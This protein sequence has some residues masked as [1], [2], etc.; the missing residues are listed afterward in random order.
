[1]SIVKESNFPINRE[2]MTFDEHIK[3]SKIQAAS[4]PVS[5]D[6]K[7]N[8]KATKSKLVIKRSAGTRSKFH[9]LYLVL[10][11]G[12]IMSCLL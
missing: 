6:Y 3:D 12:T 4:P 1:M 10:V 2:A 8:D 5:F 7:L 11:L 9:L